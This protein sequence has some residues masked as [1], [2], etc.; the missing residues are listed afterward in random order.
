MSRHGQFGVIPKMGLFTDFA[1][2]FFEH[3]AAGQ[4]FR[5]EV[6]AEGDSGKGVGCLFGWAGV[7]DQFH[8]AHLRQRRHFRCFH[9]L[10]VFPG[11]FE[12][13]KPCLELFGVSFDFGRNIVHELVIELVPVFRVR[14]LVRPLLPVG[15]IALDQLCP[16]LAV[17]APDLRRFQFE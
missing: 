8:T 17:G 16:D 6:A 11:R 9:L 2:D 4:A 5:F 13:L 14:H 3:G 10:G 7:P 1:L 12:V 15:H